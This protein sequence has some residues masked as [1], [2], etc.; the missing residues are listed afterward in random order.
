[1]AMVPWLPASIIPDGI[2]QYASRTFV[3][4]TNKTKVAILD[5]MKHRRTYAALDKN[6]QCQY[7]INGAIMGNAIWSTQGKV[8]SG[9]LQLDGATY[10]DC[11]NKPALT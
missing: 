9:A 5:A 4:A 6:I 10:V 7:T 2:K 11:G 8:G 3:L 1:M